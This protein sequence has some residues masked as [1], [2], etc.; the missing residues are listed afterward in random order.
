MESGSMCPIELGFS[1]REASNI[2]AS[3]TIGRLMSSLAVVGGGVDTPYTDTECS[4]SE[5]SYLELEL[6]RSLGMERERLGTERLGRCHATVLGG[7]RTAGDRGTGTEHDRVWLIAKGCSDGEALTWTGFTFSR[8]GRRVVTGL[9]GI[10]LTNGGGAVAELSRICGAPF[11]AR[12]VWI[13]PPY[14]AE[15]RFNVSLPL[16]WG[17]GLGSV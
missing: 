9:A 15:S 3:K 1:V 12:L 8:A 17:W 7:R 2:F 5:R 11:R 4:E 14:G 6:S 13:A 16:A 10:G